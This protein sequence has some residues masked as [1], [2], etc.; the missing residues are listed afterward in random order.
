[1]KIVATS[2]FH[3]KTYPKIPECDILLI[4]G[5][6][7]PVWNHDRNF[8]RYW[9]RSDFTD[10]LEAQ[11]AK[12]IVGIGGNH[13][14]ALSRW[15]S[16]GYELPWNYLCNESVTLDGV[17][18]WG[19]PYAP[20]FGNWSFMLPDHMLEETWNDIPS[21]IDILLTH[22]PSWGTLDE[23]QHIL[24]WES[25]EDRHV[26]SRTLMERLNGNFPNLKLFA[27]GHIHEA[28]GVVEK[29]G[30]TY[31][32]VSYVNGDYAPGQMPFVFDLERNDDN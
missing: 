32:N 3:G 20:K 19:S 9:L 26:G 15:K 25:E 14:F 11:P 12:H 24:P 30:V 2:D 10:W 6:V 23:T 27:F 28:Y 8:Q 7:T 16:L 29:D 18:I 21:D 5:D 13:D 4:G 1:M 17:K 31:A 22:G